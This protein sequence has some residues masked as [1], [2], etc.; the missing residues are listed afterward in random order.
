M[1]STENV[2]ILCRAIP[3]ESKKYFQSVCVA[4]VN[5]N[6]ELRRIYPVPFKPFEPGGGIPFRKKEW[7]SLDLRPPE[8]N[9]KRFESRK[10]DLKSAKVH[11][12]A[13]EGEVRSILEYQLRPSVKAINE[14]G[15]SL[16][17][18]KPDIKGYKLE[19]KSTDLYQKQTGLMPDGTLGRLGRIKMLQESFYEFVCENPV[20][21]SCSNKPHRM[22]IHDWEVNELY[23]KI[24]RNDTDPKEIE[25]KMRNKLLNEVAYNRDLYLMIGTHFVWKTWMIVSLIYLSKT[26]GKIRRLTEYSD[27]S[28]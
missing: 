13:S 24:V 11:N 6:K 1:N 21:C 18:I 28:N 14:S 2:L 5:E 7:V 16:G 12:K 23:R 22:E 19:I 10:V 17:I 25:R 4:G 9:D 8:S 27:Y 20:E 26:Q 15:A 3:E